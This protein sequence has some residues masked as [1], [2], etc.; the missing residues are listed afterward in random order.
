MFVDGC[1]HKG[2][3]CGIRLVKLF[4]LQSDQ[5]GW[6]VRAKDMERGRVPHI[7]SVAEAR[8]RSF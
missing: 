2:T 4:E 6:D 3:V 8:E 1:G 5:G 7:L